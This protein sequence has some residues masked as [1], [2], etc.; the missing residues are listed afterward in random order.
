M[1]L[2]NER[3][4]WLTEGSFVKFELYNQIFTVNLKS[5]LLTN[6]K[7]LFLKRSLKIITMLL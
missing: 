5:I 3:A 1:V 2:M 4:D 7:I 6:K